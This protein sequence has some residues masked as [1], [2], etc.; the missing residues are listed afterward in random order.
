MSLSQRKA[1]C[2]DL[3]CLAC[4][5][6]SNIGWFSQQQQK[7]CVF[8][9]PTARRSITY[10]YCRVGDFF[11]FILMQWTG[12]WSRYFGTKEVGGEDCRGNQ[13]LNLQPLVPEYYLAM[14]PP[15]LWSFPKM[16]IILYK[17]S[18]VFWY[19]A[20]FCTDFARDFNFVFEFAYVLL[21]VSL[22]QDWFCGSGAICGLMTCVK[23][24]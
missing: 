2:E 1:R 5:I 13:S 11:L 10:G 9:L 24:K 6:V 23:S 17:D 22:C 18:C 16:L 8:Y 15:P 21:Y 20:C 7:G 12:H 3:S 19:I 4:W 14:L